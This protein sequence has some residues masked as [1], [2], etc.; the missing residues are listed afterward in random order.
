MRSGVPG[1][2]ELRQKC[3]PSTVVGR[4]SEEHWTGRLYMRRLSIHVT[5]LAIR[6]GTPADAVTA[7][8]LLVGVA[9]AGM[10][11]VGGLWPTV[12]LVLGIQL[13]G[14]LDAVDGEVA[15]WNETT[16]PRGIYLD[17]VSH[18]LVEGTIFAGLGWRA[19]GG[20]LGSVWFPLGLIAALGVV[21]R[22]A[23]TDLVDAARAKSGMT[24][25]GDRG[26]AIRVRPLRLLRRAADFVPIH[27]AT[28][29]VEASL[30]ILAAAV[31]DA[32][33][34]DLVASR[35]LLAGLT[36][37]VWLVAFGHLVAVLASE[38]LR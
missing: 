10:L 18:Y 35:G 33:R 14:L 23:E 11:F 2:T 22:R 19:G 3:Q 29:A 12:A 36:A 38:R 27:R 1:I 20:E 21:F 4:R 34:S 16:S 30:L 31:G 26:A 5:R 13:Y 15:R 7:L 9:G 24:A 6:L 8:M 37:L 17:R 32:I 25:V 28:G